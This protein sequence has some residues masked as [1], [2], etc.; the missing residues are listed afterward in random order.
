MSIV[1]IVCFV[2]LLF[3]GILACSKYQVESF[4][5]E[6][7]DENVSRAH[8]INDYLSHPS[9]IDL[10]LSDNL[11]DPNADKEDNLFLENEAPVDTNEDIIDVDDLNVLED[12]PK[13]IDDI[14]VDD[15]GGEFI[16]SSNYSIYRNRY[17]DHKKTDIS[18][19]N[20]LSECYD[21]A[22]E[23]ITNEKNRPE[24]DLIGVEYV[25][26]DSRC[27]VF[28][29]KSKEDMKLDDNTTT[30]IPRNIDYK[31]SPYGTKIEDVDFLSDKE[32]ELLRMKSLDNNTLQD[33][34][35][36]CNRK[37]EKYSKKKNRP[38][39]ATWISSGPNARCTGRYAKDDDTATNKD[40][41]SLFGVHNRDVVTKTS[42]DDLEIDPLDSLTPGTSII[43]DIGDGDVLKVEDTDPIKNQQNEGGDVSDCDLC[44]L[45]QRDYRGSTREFCDN[46]NCENCTKLPPPMQ[47]TNF[48]DSYNS[49]EYISDIPDIVESIPDIKANV[50]LDK[51]DTIDSC[52]L[53]GK[54]GVYI[55]PID[56]EEMYKLFSKK[57]LYM[58]SNMLI[59]KGLLVEHTDGS[60]EFKG[61]YIKNVYFKGMSKLSCKLVK[62]YIREKAEKR[63]SVSYDNGFI[64]A[65]SQ[66]IYKS[67]LRAHNEKL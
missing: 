23:F 6:E 37:A 33:L 46:L 12:L 18:T 47:M 44:A 62:L 38:L 27:R 42:F 10:E 29:H 21:G 20:S 64:N 52:K 28:Y 25:P 1:L 41:Q 59:E 26:D 14:Y 36:E 22:V 55:S 13:D 45:C 60:V 54:N 63:K 34:Q 16:S 2:V 58:L 61:G 40:K 8:S 65:I 48:I 50:K 11:Q 31:I 57:D 9:K 3:I 35:S 24:S 30:F 56:T 39:I 53:P 66:V 4:Q 67:A 15:I 19:Y 43:R 7:S 17:Y 51:M 5:N 49:P 32:L